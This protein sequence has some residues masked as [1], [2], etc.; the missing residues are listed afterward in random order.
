MTTGED[1]LIEQFVDEALG[2]SAYLVAAGARKEGVLIDPPRDVDRFLKAAARKHVTITHVLDTHLHNDF[3]S[4][5]REVAART[6]AEIGASAEAQ[7]E[8]DHRPLLEGD[9]IELDGSVLEVL[10]TP[11]HTPE[12]ISFVLRDAGRTPEAL[13]SGGAL[14]VGGA[15]RT[16][17]L[18]RESTIPLARRLY[19]TIHEKLLA[20]PDDVV[21]YPTHGAGSFCVAPTGSERTTTIGAERARNPLAQATAEEEFVAT[22]LSG[23]PSYPTYFARLRPINQ[24]GPKL[25]EGPSIPK[26]LSLKAVKAW[27]DSGGAVLDVRP[28][29]EFVRGH[30]PHAY[31]IPLEAPLVTWVGWL[32]PYAEPLVLVAPGREGLAEATRQ[33]LRIGFD[34]L[35]GYLKGGLAAWKAAGFQVERTKLVS[36]AD[37]RTR[38]ATKGRPVVLDV[39]RDDEWEEGHIP[40]AVHIENGRIPEID[41]EPFRGREVVVHCAGA[42]RSTAGLSVL[43]RRGLG[44]VKLLRGGFGAWEGKGF[45]VEREASRGA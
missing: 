17:L 23:L 18:G 20:L 27:V 15:A 11:G 36:P 3:L 38:L 29:A 7:V 34:N 21:V 42:N 12:H 24:K 5:C 44:D 41:L 45:E 25:L 2:N 19:R 28:A 1:P 6:G 35:R 9:R 39:R 4:G 14:I 40:G 33:L 8:F 10:A 22:A 13:F 32:L 31:G 26:P 37:L 43:V 30:L 16:D